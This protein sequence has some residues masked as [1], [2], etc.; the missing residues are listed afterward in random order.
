[1][2]NSTVKYGSVG[3]DIEQFWIGMSRDRLAFALATLYL[4]VSHLRMKECVRVC[5]C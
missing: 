1:M 3:F 5:V 4:P 2:D